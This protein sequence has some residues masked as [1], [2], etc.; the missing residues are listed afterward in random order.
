MLY[1]AVDCFIQFNE[2]GLI[3]VQVLMELFK[4]IFKE[5]NL[6]LAKESSVLS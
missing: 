4:D 2:S 5:V 3:V 1:K 6:S